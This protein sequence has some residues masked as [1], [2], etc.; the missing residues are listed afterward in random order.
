MKIYQEI[1]LILIVYLTK[2]NTYTYKLQNISKE[3][4]FLNNDSF[5]I[6]L[7][8][9]IV[10]H[11]G[12][13][14]VVSARGLENIG[15]QYITN[16]R[17]VNLGTEESPNTTKAISPKNRKFTL[18]LGILNSQNEFVDITR[19]LCRWKKLSNGDWEIKN[20]GSEY[21]DV[22][23]FNDEYFIPD[24]FDN[25]SLSETINDTNFIRAR[26]VIPANTYAYKLIGPL[27]LKITLNHIETFSFNIFGVNHNDDEQQVEESIEDPQPSEDDPQLAPGDDPQPSE[28]DS[29]DD[30]GDD[31]EDAN[32]ETNSVDLSIQTFIT[33]NCPDG[34]DSPI[35]NGN[36]D[37]ETFD[38]GTPK[39]R[40][41]DL[42]DGIQN[43]VRVPTS[44]IN[45]QSTYNPN[46]N[47]YSVKSTKK[48]NIEFEDNNYNYFIGVLADEEQSDAIYLKGLSVEGTIDLSLLGSGQI[49]GKTWK[50]YNTVNGNNISINL[51]I[52]LDV[53]AEEG[54]YY[55]NLR[56]KFV[57]INKD[58]EG[59]EI[60]TSYYGPINSRY[61]LNNDI[62]SQNIPSFDSKYKDDDPNG[63]GISSVKQLNLTESD[64]IDK[65]GNNL[66]VGTVFKVYTYIDKYDKETNEF[67]ES[68]Q[69]FEDSQ[70]WFISTGLFNKFYNTNIQN[71]CEVQTNEPENKEFADKM[72]IVLDSDSELTNLK[73]NNTTQST[74]RGSLVSKNENIEY[75]CENSIP[76]EYEY[77]SSVSIKN[78]EELPN[79]IDINGNPELSLSKIGV[80][81][82]KTKQNIDIDISQINESNSDLVDCYKSELKKENEEIFEVKGNAQQN[83]YE[84]HFNDLFLLNVV[85]S[86]NPKIEGTIVYKDILAGI[87]NNI[88]MYQ[89]FEN[90]FDYLQSNFSDLIGHF[91]IVLNYQIEDNTQNFVD[92]VCKVSKEGNDNNDRIDQ[93]GPQN[94]PKYGQFWGTDDSSNLKGTYLNQHNV[95]DNNYNL[96]RIERN[97]NYTKFGYT[98]HTTQNGESIQKCIQTYGNDINYKINET[99][100]ATY[101]GSNKLFGYIFSPNRNVETNRKLLN[102]NL[103]ID[104]YRLND[105]DN[106]NNYEY[107][108]IQKDEIEGF[109]LTRE[110]INNAYINQ[111]RVK[112]GSEYARVW[113]RK[114]RGPGSINEW[115]LIDKLFKRPGEYVNSSSEFVNFLRND[116]KMSDY[117]YCTDQN[118]NSSESIYS[119]KNGNYKYIKPYK[120][121]IYLRFIFDIDTEESTIVKNI[122]EEYGNLKFVTTSNHEI[123]KES[124]Q[125]VLEQNINF[126]KSID[127]LLKTNDIP[128]YQNGDNILITDNNGNILNQN[129]VYYL[130]NNILKSTSDVSR[131]ELEGKPVVLCS[132]KQSVY[133]PETNSDFIR[134]DRVGGFYERNDGIPET[135]LDYSGV[136]LVS[137]QNGSN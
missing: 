9:D 88:T 21:S 129:L 48:Y 51:L 62:D 104:Y 78:K 66:P 128:I 97:A 93:A 83:S 131:Y 102:E 120:I 100:T 126:Y 69:L 124:N 95:N 80:R 92:I 33:Y 96:T 98:Y 38:E 50:F 119:I 67:I 116:V 29:E 56:F 55:K 24:E 12:D 3:V 107:I 106:I 130:N 86:T 59:N 134:Y 42:I 105:N 22:F 75:K 23:K 103:H 85:N 1:V 37:Y 8:T 71:F 109:D 64:F 7:T 77:S 2:K 30:S 65:D 72:V 81:F 15:E 112:F 53:Y 123:I 10:L 58:E 76:F 132:G 94:Y 5:L 91:G 46:N 122:P 117:I 115:V 70:R 32:T 84:E 25:S 89:K 60:G 114:Y 44:F 82:I 27:Y 45:K 47:L 110:E 118:Y 19:T 4:I 73:E 90:F 36:Q 13:K 121:T 49:V 54:I 28:D 43:E 40:I 39:F 99:N 127:N 16:Y 136:E 57:N 108:T 20:Y 26:Q 113:W 41:F 63:L 74:F 18:S 137:Y 68:I 61:T 34:V 31:S 79:C 135:V 133:N 14:F 11:A 87:G 6:P 125:F 101:F 35:L 17:N 52:G 111:E